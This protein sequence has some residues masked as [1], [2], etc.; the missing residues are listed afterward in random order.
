MNSELIL[1][2]VQEKERLKQDK[3]ESAH[4]ASTFKDKGKRKIKP[5]EAVGDSPKKQQKQIEF[6]C[7][8]CKKGEYKKENKSMLGD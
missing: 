8:F 4:L 1:Q 6:T 5:N 3:T 7:Y 2:C